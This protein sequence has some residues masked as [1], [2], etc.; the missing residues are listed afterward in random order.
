MVEEAG[1]SRRARHPHPRITGLAKKTQ[2][3]RHYT[4]SRRERGIFVS[5]HNFGPEYANRIGRHASAG[6]TPERKES[7]GFA[8]LAGGGADYAS[9]F[10]FGD[11]GVGHPEHAAKDFAVVLAQQRRGFIGL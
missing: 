1:W 2:G 10:E 5:L 4:L 3:P 6:A 8:V 7:G 11:F 9:R